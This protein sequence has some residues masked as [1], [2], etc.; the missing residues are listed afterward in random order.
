MEQMHFYLKEKY[1]PKKHSN[2]LVFDKLLV[3]WAFDHASSLK[4]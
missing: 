2:E 4:F 1:R 3:I